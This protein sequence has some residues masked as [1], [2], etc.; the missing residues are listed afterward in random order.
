MTVTTPFRPYLANILFKVVSFSENGWASLL[1]E[2]FTH[3]SVITGHSGLTVF[4]GDLGSLFNSGNSQ[5][6]AIKKDGISRILAMLANEAVFG[7]KMQIGSERC[8]ILIINHI[9]YCYV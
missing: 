9:Y 3:I 1:P 2:H 6:A 4:N 5:N 8:V 7:S